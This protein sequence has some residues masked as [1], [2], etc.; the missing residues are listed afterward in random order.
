V[1]TGVRWTNKK[2]PRIIRGATAQVVVQEFPLSETS[3]E[4]MAAQWN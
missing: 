2:K 4:L 1:A 3:E